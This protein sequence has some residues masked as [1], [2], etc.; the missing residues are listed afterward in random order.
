MEPE[1][2]EVNFDRDE[3]FVVRSVSSFSFGHDVESPPTSSEEG[4]GMSGSFISTEGKIV[5]ERCRRRSLHEVV[6]EVAQLLCQR[7]E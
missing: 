5:R 1:T 4:A 6:E 7:E 3:L 2:S